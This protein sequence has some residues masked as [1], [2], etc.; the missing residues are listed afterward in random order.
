MRCETIHVEIDGWTASSSCA[1]LDAD[2]CQKIASDILVSNAARRS[3][4]GTRLRLNA[5]AVAKG[6][7]TNKLFNM[8]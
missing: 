3:P 1:I 7:L 5:Y 4:A 6:L 2:A 8:L